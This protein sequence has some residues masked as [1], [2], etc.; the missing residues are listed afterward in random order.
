MHNDNMKPLTVYKASAGSGKTFTLATEYI[1]LV[2]DNPTAYRTILA[3][4]FTNKATE[5]MKL[6]ILSQLYGIWRADKASEGYYNKVKETSELPEREIR[7]RAG[8]ALRNLIHNYNY[9][10]VETIDTFFQS[11]LRNL[12]RELDLT[13]NLR[14][15][16]NDYQVEQQAVDRLIEDLDAKNPVLGWIMDYIN[17]NI[18]DD[19]SWN[20]IGQIKKFGENIFKD[21]Y[22][23]RSR[24][25]EEVFGQK[26]FFPEFNRQMR[27][28]RKEAQERLAEFEWAFGNDAEEKM[29][30]IAIEIARQITAANEHSAEALKK[31]ENHVS[32]GRIGLYDEE[33]LLDRLEMHLSEMA[34]NNPE[35]E[36]EIEEQI[37]QRR[38]IVELKLQHINPEALRMLKQH[39]HEL[40]MQFKE[41]NPKA[42]AHMLERRKEHIHRLTKTNP[43][44][45][46]KLRELYGE[47]GEE[48]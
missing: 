44:L 17:E 3:V 41:R 26:D 30:Q 22:K 37:E 28:I 9:F 19:K 4:T 2:I 11:V 40:A 35:N 45:A 5:E 23:S 31:A 25:L 20:V 16:L 8:M 48:S 38:S 47:N 15:G 6:R 27:A 10:R 24:R 29:E 13:A 32:W 42:Y 21:F 39:R 7:K 36:S 12:A 43:E 46:A 34:Q 18:N 1:R 14:I 33:E